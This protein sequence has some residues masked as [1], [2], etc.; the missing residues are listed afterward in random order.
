M[1]KEVK[2]SVLVTFCRQKEFIDEALKSIFNQKTNFEYEVLVGLD[3][4]DADSEKIIKKYPVKLFKCDSAKLNTIPMERASNNRLQ[5]LKNAAGKYFCF[6]DGDDFYTDN[7]RFQILV[8]VLEKNKELIGCAHYIDNFD[9]KTKEYTHTHIFLKKEIT[10]NLIDYLKHNIYISSNGFIFRNIFKEKV[11]ENQFPAI[12]DDIVLTSYMLRFGKIHYIPKLMYARRVN[13]NS[14]YESQSPEIKKIYNLLLA[15]M[16]FSLL[17]DYE[18][19]VCIRYK[20]ALRKALFIK[21]KENEQLN[22]FALKN[23]CYFSF[24]L[25][26]FKHFGLMDKINFWKNIFKYFILKQ[27]PDFNSVSPQLFQQ[28]EVLNVDS[29]LL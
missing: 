23:N 4:E 14:I 22:N 2:L 5:L 16:C 26:N 27:Y 13:V 10:L 15:E 8:D 11:S 29:A 24:C 12:V 19:L 28:E 3:G 20:K 17:S 9:N 1:G 25:Q 6:L 7:R 18:N 21:I